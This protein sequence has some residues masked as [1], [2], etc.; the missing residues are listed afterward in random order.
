MLDKILGKFGYKKVSQ[1]TEQEAI[2]VLITKFDDILLEGLEK[3]KQEQIFSS[4]SKIEG[5]GDLF[6]GLLLADMKNYFH[7]STP[8]EQLSIRG[9]FARTKVL[10]NLIMG[11]TKEPIKLTS[12]RHG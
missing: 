10:R 5:I 3:E 2:D 9:A 4:I 11:K 12:E 6:R 7:A 8:V 1:I